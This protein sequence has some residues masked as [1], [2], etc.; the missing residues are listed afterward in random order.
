M[1]FTLTDISSCLPRRCMELGAGPVFLRFPL[2]LCGSSS[3]GLKK[4]VDIDRNDK[5]VKKTGQ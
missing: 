1:G 3:H 2:G 4:I 5:Q